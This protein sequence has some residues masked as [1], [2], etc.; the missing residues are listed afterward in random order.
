MNK[1]V[2][3]LLALALATICGAGAHA[4]DAGYGNDFFASQINYD[5]FNLSVRKRLETVRIGSSLGQTFAGLRTASTPLF[6]SDDAFAMAPSSRVGSY[7]S[8][9]RRQLDCVYYNGFTLWGDMYA[10]WAQQRAH[11]GR[12]GYRHKVF[13]P[14]IGFDWTTGGF[15]IGLGTTYNWGKMH[16]R[17]EQNDRRTRQWA[18]EIYG[19]YN[20][21]RFYVNA[22]VG[23]GHNDIR[24]H[25][26]NGWGD[27]YSTNSVNLDAEF[28]WKFNWSG[29]Q[30]VP[31]AGARF[32]HDRHGEINDGNIRASSE[33]YHVFEVPLGINVAYEV[34]TGGM[35]F[36]PRAK[37][38]YT[39][40]LFRERNSVDGDEGARRSRNGFNVGLGMEAKITKSI[41]AHVDYNCNFRPRQYEHHWNMGVGF[42]F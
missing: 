37:F 5:S 32:F 33:N 40:E 6:A 29:L 24:S 36:V 39:P 38:G 14:A 7:S 9:S 42:T 13:G 41:S 15:T 8:A 31:H 35:T 25:R 19:Q 28:G 10:T 18:A 27:K 17:D 23:Y 12:D 16:G 22:T 2:R 1:F 3:P 20:A 34:N 30:I 26:T 4:L 21:D 11:H